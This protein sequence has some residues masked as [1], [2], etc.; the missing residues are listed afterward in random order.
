M[1]NPAK[2]YLIIAIALM[3]Y[4][5]M[6]FWGVDLIINL[7]AKALP[8]QQDGP[9]DGFQKVAG[10][11][12]FLTGILMLFEAWNSRQPTNQSKGDKP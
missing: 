4:S 6:M 8:V 12:I 3:A 10:V 11:L 2:S 7:L 1:Q 5:I 9:F